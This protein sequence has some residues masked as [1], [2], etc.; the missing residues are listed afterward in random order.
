[1][2]DGRK[3]FAM[4]LARTVEHTTDWRAMLHRMEPQEFNEWQVLYRIQPWGIELPVEDS[5]AEARDSQSVFRSM[6]GF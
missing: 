3:Q 6:A 4:F 2:A 5:R 1:M